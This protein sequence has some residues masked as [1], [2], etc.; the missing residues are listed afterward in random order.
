MFTGAEKEVHTN[1]AP[2]ESGAAPEGSTMPSA[3]PQAPSSQA[4]PA[5][6]AGSSR[7]MPAQPYWQ[8]PPQYYQQW[9]Q[10]APGVAPAPPAMPTMPSLPFAPNLPAPTPEEFQRV[11]LYAHMQQQQ[12]LQQQQQQGGQMPSNFPGYPYFGYHPGMMGG[13]P[14]NLP[15]GIASENRESSMREKQPTRVAASK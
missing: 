15:H 2:T 5:H 6:P 13:M 10:A 11:M 1:E 9:G 4:P 12:H 8:H 3:E 14:A 7:A